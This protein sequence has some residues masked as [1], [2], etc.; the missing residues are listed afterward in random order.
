MALD[1][2][3]GSDIRLAMTFPQDSERHNIMLAMH[4][5]MEAIRTESIAEGTVADAPGGL[6]FIDSEATFMGEMQYEERASILSAPK[7]VAQAI[8]ED[9]KRAFRKA[10][11]AAAELKL[12]PKKFTGDTLIERKFNEFK[13]KFSNNFINTKRQILFNI[14]DR[15]NPKR[16]AEGEFETY[17]EF[18]SQT[19]S[20]GLI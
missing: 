11:N 5:L 19:N 8:I 12:R 4:Q 15:Y 2:V 16:N 9:Q 17:L 20:K 7:R 1:Q 10:K 13:D 6:D 3:K 14:A 18:L